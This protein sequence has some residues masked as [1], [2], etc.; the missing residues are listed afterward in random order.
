MAAGGPSA[1]LMYEA[2]D[3]TRLSLQLRRKAQG[4]RPIRAS[5]SKGCRRL[6]Q[7]QAGSRGRRHGVLLDH[8]PQPR[9]RAG[10]PVGSRTRPLTGG[11]VRAAPAAA[12]QGRVKRIGQGGQKR[13][14]SGILACAD[15]TH[16]RIQ[17]PGPS[18]KHQGTSMLI[19]SPK[20]LRGD[21]IAASE[22]TPRHV[23]AARRRLLTRC[24]AG[25]AGAALSPWLAARSPCPARPAR[26]EAGGCAQQCF[27]DHGEAHAPLTM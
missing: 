5:G 7:E 15:P 21:D 8:R 23:F 17:I 19:P 18:E 2:D 12:G 22:I 13:A 27:R 26:A 1:I 24:A 4:V 11:A 20:W 14:L 16:G 3:G 10:R 6:R 9:L 25:T